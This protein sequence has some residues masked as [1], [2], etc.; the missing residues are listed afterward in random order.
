MSISKEF[1]EK[2]RGRLEEEPTVPTGKLASELGVSEAE[3]I[4]ALPVKMRRK[5]RPEDLKDI[6][7]AVE[8]WKNVRLHNSSAG[9]KGMLGKIIPS[10]PSQQELGYIWFVSKPDQGGESHSVRFLSKTGQHMLSVYLGRNGNQGI[11]PRDKA[12]FEQMRDHFGITPTPK[13][14]CKGCG[15]CTCGGKHKNHAHTH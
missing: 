8:G 5:A 15:K 3:V 1:V 11:D 7:Q 10:K 9:A 14:G 2:V 13:M 12:A 4:I 6:W